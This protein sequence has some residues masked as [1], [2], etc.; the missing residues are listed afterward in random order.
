[1]SRD[2]Q[3][4]FTMSE[5]HKASLARGRSE[6]RVVRN[7]LEAIAAG[8][9]RRRARSA[10]SIEARIAEIAADLECADAI[11]RLRLVQERRDLRHEL[12][13]NAPEVDIAALEAAFVDVGASYSQRH[14]ISYESWREVGVPA[15]TLRRAGVSRG[16]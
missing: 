13:T 9:K 8:P 7:Y 3:A 1:M 2:G 4:R 15:T 16:R 6:G 11:E 12:A 14:G 10:A 5:A